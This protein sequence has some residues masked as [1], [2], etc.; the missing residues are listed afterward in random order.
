MCSLMT[1]SVSFRT[2]LS[3]FWFG[4][5]RV[6]G[7]GELDVVMLGEA[8]VSD[9]MFRGNDVVDDS[10]T[11]AGGRLGAGSGTGVEFVG[12]LATPSTLV[13]LSACGAEA[14]G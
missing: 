7:A 4:V 8:E 9:L 10:T 12:A 6:S 13:S 1:L 5:R 3:W 11:L 2:W 14:G